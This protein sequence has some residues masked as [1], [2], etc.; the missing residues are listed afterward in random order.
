[1]FALNVVNAQVREGKKK[2]ALDAYL[3]DSCS[4]GISAIDATLV[5]MREVAWP[6]AGV[7]ITVTEHAHAKPR[8]M[9]EKHFFF[10]LGLVGGSYS[11]VSIAVSSVL[12]SY[13][14]SML[15]YASTATQLSDK[16]SHPLF[17]RLV[18]SD[19]AQVSPQMQSS[20][21]SGVTTVA[22][23]QTNSSSEL[24]RP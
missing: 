1:M 10:C 4:N 13:N 6:V 22:Q 3:V 14:V 17:G 5:A 23:Q 19:D 2:V 20:I 12:Q 18:P 16:Q 24:R 9:Q 8:I 21:T 11:S 7:T 15:S